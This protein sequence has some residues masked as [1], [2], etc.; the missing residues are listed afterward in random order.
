[1]AARRAVTFFAA[2]SF[3]LSPLLAGAQEATTPPHIAAAHA[4]LVAWGHEQWDQLQPLA[5]DAVTVKLGDE[6][7]RLEPATKRSAIA[8]IF[9]F[10]RLSTVRMGADVKQITVDD[11][12]LRVGNKE[13]R[14]PATLS[15]MELNGQFQVTGVT[16]N[17]AEEQSERAEPTL[18]GSSPW[19]P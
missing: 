2:L 6:V 8:V 4:F 13:V 3:M 18:T 11:L 5:A 12:A 16:L 7:F 14:G 1:M 19:S 15:L 9:P 10:R 17:T